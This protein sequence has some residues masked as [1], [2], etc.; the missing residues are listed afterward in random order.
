MQQNQPDF[1]DLVL[2]PAGISREQVYKFAMQFSLILIGIGLGATLDYPIAIISGTI[3]LLML[4]FLIPYLVS[5]LTK[6]SGET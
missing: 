3:W 5:F 4:K 1:I 2:A 6:I